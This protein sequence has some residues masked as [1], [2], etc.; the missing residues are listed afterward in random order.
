MKSMKLELV[1]TPDNN[2]DLADVVASML[3]MSGDRPGAEGISVLAGKSLFKRAIGK[4]AVGAVRMIGAAGDNTTNA[5][6]MKLRPFITDKVNE[7][8]VKYHITASVIINSVVKEDNTMKIVLEA[9]AI[10]YKGIITHYLP[11]ILDSVRKKD[12][13]S[14]LIQIT[15]IIENDKAAVIGAVLDNLSDEKKEAIV[16]LLVNRYDRVIC[17]KISEYLSDQNIAIKVSQ[18]GIE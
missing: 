3:D 12:S 16:K 4:A 8:L 13:Q 15:D 14:I 7:Y 9:D 5:L 6:L 18:I 11:Q 2:K 17:D 1:L 10:D